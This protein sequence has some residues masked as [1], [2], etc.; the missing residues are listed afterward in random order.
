MYS[1]HARFLGKRD[2]LSRSPEPSDFTLAKAEENDREQDGDKDQ[3]LAADYD[4]SLDR[5][6]DEEKRVG[7]AGVAKGEPE[8]DEVEEYE[9]EMEEEEDLDD[10][11]AVAMGEKKPKKVK[12]VSVSTALHYR[13]KIKIH[14]I[15]EEENSSARPNNN[16][17]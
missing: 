17:S 7:G 2:S 15:T 9:E 10:M 11:F 3:I 12:K 16:H 6:E 4:P 13:P 1:S 8:P 5:R 14:L